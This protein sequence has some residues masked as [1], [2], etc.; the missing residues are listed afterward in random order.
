[1]LRRRE[2]IL[3]DVVVFNQRHVGST[4]APW[5]FTRFLVMVN[6]RL[7]SLSVRA[8]A[9]FGRS[10]HEPSGQD[11]VSCLLL[12]ALDQVADVGLA[13]RLPVSYDADTLREESRK[14]LVDH[15]TLVVDEEWQ[16]GSELCLLRDFG[17]D[18]WHFVQD[19]RAVGTHLALIALSA[20]LS[21][22]TG[23]AID[24][25]VRHRRMLPS[26]GECPIAS[27]PP[28]ASVVR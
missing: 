11:G 1:M 18:F 27:C 5:T 26:F 15:Q 25:M 28:H 16:S 13:H 23:H 14:W 19:P 2:T 8:E 4:G 3:T 7:K 21:Q 24:A 9:A 10:V 6:R 20:V 12:A 22:A 17:A